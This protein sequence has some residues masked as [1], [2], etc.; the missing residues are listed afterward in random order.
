VNQRR[1]YRSA[2]DRILAG[3]AGGVAAYFDVDPVIVRIIW[4]LSVFFTGS[5]TFWAYIVM[6][7]VVPVEPTEWSAPA[8]PWAPGGTPIG[9]APAGYAA[10]YTPPADGGTGQGG[11]AAPAGTQPTAETPEGTTAPA[12][13]NAPP[14]PPG[15][16]PFVAGQPNQW[17]PAPAS[18]WRW[19]R[20]ADRWQRRAER[21]EVRGRGNG[22]LMFGLILIV[23]GGLLAWHQID[24]N[25]DLGLAWPIGVVALGVVLVASSVRFG[26]RS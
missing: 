24:P 17:G 8:T 20:R 16:A 25:I 12:D 7:I 15:T 5:L 11:E 14:V 23:V 6:I 21:M 26:N 19:Q 10:Y 2:D 13:P 22:G 4:F 1:L 3:V 18:D 9:N